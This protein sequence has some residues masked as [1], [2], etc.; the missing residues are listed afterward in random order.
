MA[1]GTVASP[2]L[3][4]P[5]SRLVE[6]PPAVPPSA[7]EG[8]SPWWSPSGKEP[9]ISN[10]R[11]GMLVF[12]AFETMFFG[13][14]LGAFLVF[15]L[16]SVRW[17]PP[18]Q[19]YLPGAITWINTGI[20]LASSYTMGR[21]LRAIRAGDHSGLLHG[22]GITALLGTIFLAVQGTEWVRLVRFG[23]TLSSGIYGS[24][25]YTLI[26]CHGLHVLGAVAWL[27]INLLQAIGGRFTARD[28]VGVQLC[29][30]YWYFVVSLWPVLF[31]LVYLF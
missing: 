6:V 14:L 15:R 19:P 1:R 10:A 27:L 20:L 28:H 25:F 5:V 31:G 18:G 13:G 3:D 26:G 12:L 29:G 9:V 17:P 24:T 7:G 2:V 30:M 11:L 21:A 16:S 22:L 23:L 8:P 4:E